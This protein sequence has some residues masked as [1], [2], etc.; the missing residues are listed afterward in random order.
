MKIKVSIKV[1][2]HFYVTTT[3]PTTSTTTLA[4]TFI[5]SN[6]KWIAFIAI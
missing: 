3:R 2:G 5:K 6:I 1:I 4:A